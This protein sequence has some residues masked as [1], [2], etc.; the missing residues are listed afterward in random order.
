[1]KYQLKKLKKNFL[2]PIDI[3]YIPRYSSLF[4]NNLHIKNDIVW[5]SEH[6]KYLRT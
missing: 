4:N 2:V 3:R 5:I 6:T 1:M